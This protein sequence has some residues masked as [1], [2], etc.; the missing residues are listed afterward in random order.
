MLP[1][2]YRFSFIS[3]V[4]LWACVPVCDSSNQGQWVLKPTPVDIWQA[5]TM[6]MSHTPFTY[7]YREFRIFE[8]L[9]LTAKLKH[10]ITINHTDEVFMAKK[11]N[12]YITVGNLLAKR[13]LHV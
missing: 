8:H 2:S 11:K 1:S 3:L 13:V 12:V 5:G 9:Q 10:K 6:D 7:S 4:F